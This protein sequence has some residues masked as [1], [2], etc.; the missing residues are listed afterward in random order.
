MDVRFW[1][2]V[3]FLEDYVLCFVDSVLKCGHSST[4]PMSTITELHQI[5]LNS[6]RITRPRWSPDGRF[7]AVPT[8]S[9]SIAIFDIDTQNIRQTL[10]SHSADVTA[11][12]WNRTSDAILS[13]SLDGSVGLW[14]I[15]SGTRADFSISGHREP[16]HSVEW[17]DEEAFAMTCSVDRV[18]AWD[19]CCLLTGW[20]KEMEDGVN[21][22]TG[23]TAASCSFQTT[24]LLAMVAENGGLLVLASLITG[25]VLDSV[26][27]EDPVQSLAWSPADELLAVGTGDTI[28]AFHATQ[29]G[30]EKPPR[31]M[32]IHAPRVHALAFSSDGTR[33]ASRDVQGLKIWDVKSAMLIAT[34]DESVE[35]V[36]SGIAFHPARPWL[37]TVS[38]NETAFR[39][40][41]LSDLSTPA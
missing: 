29:T 26:R 7:L 15:Q 39:V 23:L 12:T 30:F 21:R 41:D 9:G 3:Q 22:Y 36:S 5:D 28:L 31:E 27:M 17:T 14:E 2:P 8:Q 25:D 11:V 38:P 35:R 37:A 10:R 20:T 19:G 18:R 33:L 1:A 32:T 24:F 34:L 40:L 13:A 6:G 16:V 4:Q